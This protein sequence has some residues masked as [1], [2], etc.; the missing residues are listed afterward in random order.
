[1]KMQVAKA[2]NAATM[3]CMSAFVL[4]QKL[5]AD[6]LAVADIGLCAV[7]LMNDAR[8][9]WLILVPKR[10]DLREIHELTPLDQTILTF[11]ISQMSKLLQQSTGALKMNVAALGNQ[12]AQ[13]HVHVIARFEDDPAWPNPVWGSGDPLTYEAEKAQRLIESL[14]SQI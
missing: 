4:D 11:E 8:Y 1:M 5:E 2:Q 9:P 12:V 13:L 6:T 7:R 3:P 14:I 10:A